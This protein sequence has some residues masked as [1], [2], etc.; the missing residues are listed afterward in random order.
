MYGPI[1]SPQIDNWQGP[2][3]YF[4]CEMESDLVRGQK[5]AACAYKA[6]RSL[7]IVEPRS[8]ELDI[9]VCAAH[10][11]WAFLQ[12]QGAVRTVLQCSLWVYFKAKAFF[13]LNGGRT[14]LRLWLG[15]STLSSVP[16]CRSQ[17]SPLIS[18]KPERTTFPLVKRKIDSLTSWSLD[19]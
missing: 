14:M 6:G 2:I 12:L 8:K 7:E 4:Q 11:T 9:F 1:F 19:W 16:S 5:G 10:N 15:H 13:E 17:A 3:C 18:W